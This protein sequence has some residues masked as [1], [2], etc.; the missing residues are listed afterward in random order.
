[1][2]SFVSTV[3]KRWQVQR[4]RRR[5]P[6]AR[7]GCWCLRCS[8]CWWASRA[9]CGCSTLPP[10][11]LP[12]SPLATNRQLRSQEIVQTEDPFLILQAYRDDQLDVFAADLEG[13]PLVS[14]G[15]SADWDHL[16]LSAVD[17]RYG[18][19][20]VRWRHP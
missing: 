7:V 16:P 11:S 6:G 9:C 8:C 20:R 2:M 13:N 12:A 17:D 19:G 14:F 3:A 18:P 4:R 15:A 5:K 1:M 10:A